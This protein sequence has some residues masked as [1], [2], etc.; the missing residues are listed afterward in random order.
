MIATLADSNVDLR[1]LFQCPLSGLVGCNLDRGRWP[2]AIRVSMPFKRAGWLQPSLSWTT[3][4]TKRFQCPLSGLVGC[5]NPR[6]LSRPMR[7]WFQCPLSGLVGCNDSVTPFRAA[8]VAFQCPLS[9]LVGCNADCA[10]D[11]P[12]K[13]VFQCL[14]SGL[15]GCNAVSTSPTGR[16]DSGFNAL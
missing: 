15:V 6:R 12:G 3:T 4:K 2:R 9:G 10:G 8:N 13:M 5:N 1:S 14:L 7:Q 16:R 11:S